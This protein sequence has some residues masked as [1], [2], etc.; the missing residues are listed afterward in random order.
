M[1]KTQRVLVYGDSVALAGVATSLSLDP[2][3]EVLG[4]C[5]PMREEE[6]ERCHP[7]ALIFELNAL[8]PAFV[9]AVSRQLPGLLLIGIDLETNR[10]FLWTGQQMEGWTSQ[11]LARAIRHTGKAGQLKGPQRGKGHK[12]F[13]GRNGD[14]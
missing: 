9:Y 8:P 11:D 6:L 14:P 2:D 10:A 1:G 5:L 12:E 13:P 7:D 4:H 3:C